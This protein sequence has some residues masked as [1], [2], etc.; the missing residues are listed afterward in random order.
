MADF[1]PVAWPVGRFWQSLSVFRRWRR[2]VRLPKRWSGSCLLFS[3]ICRAGN[4][5]EH[6]RTAAGSARGRRL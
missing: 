1:L 4:R 3:E 5:R 6:S 2:N